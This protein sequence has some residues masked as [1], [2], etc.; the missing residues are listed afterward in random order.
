MKKFFES[1][2]VGSGKLAVKQSLESID[3]NIKWIRDH[4]ATVVSWL[5][6][7]PS[8]TARRHFQ[9]TYYDEIYKYGRP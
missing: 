8:V 1:K 5:D 6:S 7:F 9:A 4:S 2:P 3:A